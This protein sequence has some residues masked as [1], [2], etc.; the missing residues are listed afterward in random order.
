MSCGSQAEEMSDSELLSTA[1]WQA[2]IEGWLREMQASG[3]DALPE[4]AASG[5]PRVATA[6]CVR[7]TRLA[8]LFGSDLQSL[9]EASYPE[10]QV[11]LWTGYRLGE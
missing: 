2:E 1:D 3:T 4:Q 7:S 11:D 8:E 10:L 6:S 5:N 9:V